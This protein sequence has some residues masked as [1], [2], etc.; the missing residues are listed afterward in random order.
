MHYEIHHLGSIYDINLVIYA[1]NGLDPS[2]RKFIASIQTR[3]NPIMFDV[4][5]IKLMDY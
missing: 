2:F 4:L 5:Y 3:E 1:L